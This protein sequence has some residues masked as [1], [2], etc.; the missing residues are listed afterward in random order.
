MHRKPLIWEMRAM[1]KRF[2]TLAALGIIATVTAATAGTARAGMTL[3]LGQPDLQAGVRIVVPLT[4]SCSP[5][6][7][8]LAVLPRASSYR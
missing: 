8:S 7:P 2:F 1:R 5:F 3:N 6:D 4:V